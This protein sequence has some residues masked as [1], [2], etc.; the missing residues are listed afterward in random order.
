VEILPGV[1]IPVPGLQ[2]TPN[3]QQQQPQ[4]QPSD[5]G[6]MSGQPVAPDGVWPTTAEPGV[7]NDPDP[8]LSNH[9]R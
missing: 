7:T 2:P 1:R 5:A 9:N 6:P 4:Q 3:A 8:S